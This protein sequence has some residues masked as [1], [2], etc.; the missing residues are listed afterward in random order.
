VASGLQ[1]GLGVCRLVGDLGLVVTWKRF[2][3]VEEPKHIP[4]DR[5]FPQDSETSI[6]LL[7]NSKR[8]ER[9]FCAIINTI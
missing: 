6:V 4:F 8:G 2:V 3:S 9:G 7:E 1:I 5:N